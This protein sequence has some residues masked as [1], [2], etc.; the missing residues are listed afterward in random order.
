MKRVL[1]IFGLPGSGKSTLAEKLRDDYSFEILSLDELYAEFIKT[2]CPNLYFEALDKFIA[3][4]YQHIL[5]PIEYSKHHFGRNFVEEWHEYLLTATSDRN[6]RHDNLVVEGF[7]LYDY[8][9]N[10]ESAMSQVA[11]V[12]LVQAS[13]R[14]Y[15]VVGTPLTAKDIVPL[16]LTDEFKVRK[17][18]G[19]EGA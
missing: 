16:G 17:R 6:A 15:R 3:P 19:D 7:L 13:N 2:K 18:G 9:S 14:T 4:H 8:L 11:Q 10:L 12:F 1:L 5:H